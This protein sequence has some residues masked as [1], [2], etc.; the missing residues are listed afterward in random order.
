MSM[1]QPWLQPLQTVGA[2]ERY[3]TRVLKR[4]FRSVSAPTGQISTTLAE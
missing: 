3:Q 4:N 2:L 1:L